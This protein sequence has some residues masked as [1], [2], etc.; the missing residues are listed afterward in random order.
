MEIELKTILFPILN[1]FLYFFEI[2][3][4]GGR[5]KRIEDM[6]SGK[7]GIEISTTQIWETKFVIS[8]HSSSQGL[9]V[10]HTRR[11]W[12]MKMDVLHKNILQ[13]SQVVVGFYE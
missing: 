10:L 12:Q 11:D 7:K 1:I 6:A 9:F 2:E 4:G 3:F 8:V 13:W 5:K